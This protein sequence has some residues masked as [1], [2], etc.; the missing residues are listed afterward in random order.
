MS[1]ACWI[2][3]ENFHHELREA[4]VRQQILFCRNKLEHKEMRTAEEWS[5][6]LGLNLLD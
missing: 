3:S 5:N 1:L 4:F 2:L 6:I